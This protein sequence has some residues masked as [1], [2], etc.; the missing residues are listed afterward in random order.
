MKVCVVY[1]PHSGSERENPS[2]QIVNALQSGGVAQSDITVTFADQVDDDASLLRSHDVIVIWGGDGTACHLI[3]QIK[4]SKPIV[5]LPGGTMNMLYRAHY[6]DP[7][8]WENTLTESVAS[9]HEVT[10]TSGVANDRPFFVAASF[11]QLSLLA[12]ARE[13]LRRGDPVDAVTTLVDSSDHLLRDQIDVSFSE[14]DLN[15]IVGA[16]AIGAVLEFGHHP[17]FDVG[18]LDVSTLVDLTAVAMRSLIDDWKHSDRIDA[19]RSREFVLTSSGDSSR[20]THA[21]LDG[22]PLELTFPIKVLVNEN[23]GTLLCPK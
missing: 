6:G 23:A 19:R 4:T 1:N 17:Y 15:E 3:G 8:D 16:T 20:V 12:E 22:E 18:A 9:A 13:A 2:D 21:T 11:G 14:H 10:L 7:A 5:L